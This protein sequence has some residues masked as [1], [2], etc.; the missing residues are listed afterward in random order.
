MC[1]IVGIIAKNQNGFFQK[2]A[3]IFKQMLYADAIRGW[4]ATGVFGVN[5]AGNLDIKKQASAAGHFVHTNEYDNFDSNIFQKYHFVVGHNRKATHG[6]KNNDSAHPFW[7]KKEKICLVHNGMISNQKDFCPTSTVDSA[8]IA[9]ALA[10]TEDIST[11]IENIQGAYAFVWYNVEQKRIYFLRNASRPLYISETPTT[12]IISS[13]DSLAYWV[14][15]RNNTPINTTGLFEE[16]TPYYIDMDEKVLYQLNKIEQKKTSPSTITTHITCN[17]LL[18][19]QRTSQYNKN[20]R[21]Q[22]GTQDIDDL[23]Y[24]DSDFSSAGEVIAKIKLNSTLACKARTYEKIDNS[25]HYKIHLDIINVNKSYIDVIL[26]LNQK[27]FD[28]LD[29]TALMEVTLKSSIE[30]NGMARLF[31]S[32]PDTL[33]ENDWIITANET[34]ITQGMWFDD[35]FPINCDVCTERLHWEQLE[36]SNIH[37]EDKTVISAIC[38]KCSGESHSVQ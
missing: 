25:N 12:W 1:G 16:N 23:Y 22:I 37:I 6:E 20:S 2:D 3:D 15:K 33:D 5:K 14:A 35:R 18:P 27:E 13:E 11:V 10:K 29:L 30:I 8:A 4:D 26:F 21:G 19:T 17:N 32:S 34:I 7:D 38:P 9:E 36:N 24:S 28:K 31:V